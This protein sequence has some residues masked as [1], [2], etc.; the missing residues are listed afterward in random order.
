MCWR[1]LGR[2]SGFA[3]L[4]LLSRRQ[5]CGVLAG[6]S[7]EAA[8]EIKMLITRS[9]EKVESGSDMVGRSG[10]TLNQIV[11]SVSEVKELMDA[12]AIAGEQQAVGV[13]EINRSMVSMDSITQK[14]ALMVTQ[15]ANASVAMKDEV[16]TL[17][18]QLS[19]FKS[20]DT[21]PAEDHRKAA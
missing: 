21:K 8:R 7:A 14:N 10:Q 20:Q 9:V 15:V 1:R 5:R 19:F 4:D 2:L 11:E 6:R 13:E 18:A 16:E 12:M 17:N 3:V